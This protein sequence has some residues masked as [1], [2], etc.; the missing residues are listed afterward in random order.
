MTKTV[1]KRGNWPEV[2]SMALYFIRATPCVVH[3]VFTLYVETPVGTGDS[4]TTTLIA[5]TSH[6]SQNSLLG[7]N[8]LLSTLFVWP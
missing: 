7:Q 4:H 6:T 8:P 2:I 1:D 3:Q 5:I